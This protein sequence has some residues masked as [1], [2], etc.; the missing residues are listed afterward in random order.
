[1]NKHKQKICWQIQSNLPKS[2]SCNR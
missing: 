1:M 2:V